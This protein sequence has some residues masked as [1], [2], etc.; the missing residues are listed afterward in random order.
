MK[1]L[2]VLGTGNAQSDLIEYGKGR[3]EV[4]ACSYRPGDTA[5]KLADVFVPIDITDAEAVSA[6]AR[7]QG[8]NLVYSVGSDLAMPT[9]GLVSAH[10]GLPGFVSAWTAST[11]QSKDALRRLLEGKPYNLGHRTL[12]SLSD[13]EGLAYP[14]MVK[15]V[16]SQGQRGVR[17]VENAAE[18]AE[19]LPLAL[20]HSRQKTLVAEDYVDGPEFSAN[21]YS[22][23]GE[24][25][26]SLISA[27]VVWE[28]LPGGII[29]EHR[30][31]HGISGQ[32]T[33]A[34]IKA[35]IKDTLEV[36]ALENGPS[37]FQFKLTRAHHPK[38]IEVTPRLD[39]CHLWRLIEMSTGVNLLDWTMRH[40]SGD[41]SFVGETTVDPKDG[42]LQFYCQPPGTSFDSALHRGETAFRKHYYQDGETVRSLN[43]HMEKCGYGIWMGP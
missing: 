39:G 1:K 18:L 35:M 41:T 16:D 38:L 29:R 17:K 37:Y 6:Y 15:P 3:Y 21:V 23:D 43:G 13:A 8:I 19:H 32:E 28:D 12:R 22:V 24:I 42:R 7:A 11:C 2:L 33:L 9:V 30:I 36:L 10:L 31:P 14:C 20:T 4:H 25:V 40:L 26:F 34:E 27:R 5:E